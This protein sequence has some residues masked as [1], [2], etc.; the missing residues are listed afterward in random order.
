[1]RNGAPDEALGPA[2]RWEMRYSQRLA[3]AS[4]AHRE[5]LASLDSDIGS[6]LVQEG[7][8]EAHVVV[9]GKTQVGKTSLILDLMGVLPEAQA[10]VSKVLRGE[11]EDGESATAMATGYR[12]APDGRWQLQVSPDP[13]A[14]FPDDEGMTGALAAIR[15]R[16]TGRELAATDRCTIFIPA[17]CF[18]PESSASQAMRM[19]DL[20]GAHARDTV[21]DSY[22]H[23]VARKNVPCADLIL[24]VGKADDLG[25]LK[26]EALDVPGIEDWQLVPERFRI[27]TTFSFTP[28]SV[29]DAAS[30][31]RHE[32]DATFFRTRLFEQLKTTG[33]SLTE[34]ANRSK[35]FFPLEFGQSWRAGVRGEHGELLRRLSPLVDDLKNQLREDIKAST[36]EYARFENA[37]RAHVVVARV[38]EKR[39]QERDAEIA[40]AGKEREAARRHVSFCEKVAR[41]NRTQ[42]ADLVEKKRGL[43][44]QKLRDNIA[45]FAECENRVIAVELSEL[46]LDGGKPEAAYRG[47]VEVVAR[48]ETVSSFQILLDRFASVLR[49]NALDRRPPR[50]SFLSDWLTARKAVDLESC[51]GALDR[52]IDVQLFDARG[53][54]A[55][56]WTDSYVPSSPFSDWSEDQMRVVDCMEEASRAVNVFMHSLWMDRAE[57]GI[58]SLGEDIQNL[59]RQC[60]AD[61]LK[62]IEARRRCAVL[63]RSMRKKRDERDVYKRKMEADETAGE[64][65]VALMDAH[66][67]KEL[68]ERRR[69]VGESASPA[70]R[71]VELLACKHLVIERRKLKE[72][73]K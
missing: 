54:L 35:R 15:K 6:Q 39:L 49:R 33:V 67:L 64:R 12:R 4:A 10:R 2:R 66:Y 31:C 52:L 44:K 19:L 27:I 3:W 7:P 50:G 20:P 63:S 41:D 23:E 32:L 37:Y 62:L 34:E 25:F 53:A 57:A 16:M 8:A 65:F 18:A 60:A 61:E 45:K 73:L 21:E 72:R 55:S 56:H 29:I 22:V 59:T 11:R 51:S 14:T 13:V 43:T 48:K 47:V 9:Y 46:Y 17:S 26:P 24:L 30:A 40:L 71:L 5:L 36:G 38:K 68:R 70:A 69:A 42:V 28:Q 1:M 58:C